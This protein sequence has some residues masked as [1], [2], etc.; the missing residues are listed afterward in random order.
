MDILGLV[1]QPRDFSARIFPLQDKNMPTTDVK[2]IYLAMKEF[3]KS[4]IIQ[5]DRISQ[6]RDTFERDFWNNYYLED[7]KILTKRYHLG[8]GAIQITE[9]SEKPSEILLELYNDKLIQSKALLFTMT[10]SFQLE[11]S[12]Y[13]YM[14]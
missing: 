5:E 8:F 2:T 3:F 12:K 1:Y 10:E 13:T 4:N 7:L 6:S 11:N 9:A 14:F